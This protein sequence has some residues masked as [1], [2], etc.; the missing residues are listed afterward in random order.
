LRLTELVEAPSEKSVTLTVS[1][2]DLVTKP[3]DA[4]IVKAKVLGAAA[5]EGVTNTCTGT[6]ASG[7]RN[8]NVGA[9]DAATPGGAPETCRF[10]GAVKPL[11]EARK[12]LAVADSVIGTEIS[13]FDKAIEKSFIVSWIPADAKVGPLVPRITGTNV[14][15]L[16]RGAA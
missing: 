9:I 10:T 11:R 5:L 4:V 8:T 2:V 16:A 15:R 3:L 13:E 7:F 14:P 6:V 1:A 12:T